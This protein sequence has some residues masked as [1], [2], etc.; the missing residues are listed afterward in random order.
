M[1]SGKTITIR[2]KPYVKQFL[3]QNYGYPVNLYSCA[4]AFIYPFRSY[5]RMPDNYSLPSRVRPGKRPMPKIRPSFPNSQSDVEVI[6]VISSYDFYHY[7]W[8]IHSLHVCAL[9]TAFEQAAKMFMRTFVTIHTVIT[10]SQSTS[11]RKFQSRYDYPDD[12]W[13]YQ[14]IKKDLYRNSIDVEIDFEKEIF[15]KI[16]KIIMYNLYSLGT[17]SKKNHFNH[18]FNCKRPKQHG[19]DSQSMVDSFIPDLFSSL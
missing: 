11:I 5:L 7:G 2:T 6:F 15:E 9:N 8:E 4:N 12:I 10:G 1:P 17:L 16:Q 19:G 14:S 3:I 13:D 18:E